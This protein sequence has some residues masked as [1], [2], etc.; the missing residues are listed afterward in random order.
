MPSEFTEHLRAF[1]Q[2]DSLGKTVILP[3]FDH[4]KYTINFIAS[5]FNCSKY[6]V[7]KARNWKQHTVGT[8]YPTKNKIKRN[9]LGI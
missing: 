7:R 5:I 8:E 6:L 1:K 9:K 4:K 3:L 2:S